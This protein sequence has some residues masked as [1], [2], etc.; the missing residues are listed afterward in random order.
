MNHEECTPMEIDF[1]HASRLRAP[2]S[3]AMPTE[4]KIAQNVSKPHSKTGI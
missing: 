4:K 2:V 1:H 3:Y